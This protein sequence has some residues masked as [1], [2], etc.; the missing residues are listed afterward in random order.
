MNQNLNKIWK[1]I[2]IMDTIPPY[3]GLNQIDLDRLTFARNKLI[4]IIFSNGYEVNY[5][6]KRLVKSKSPRTLMPESHEQR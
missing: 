3:N 6:T 5:T 4:N 2:K 1:T